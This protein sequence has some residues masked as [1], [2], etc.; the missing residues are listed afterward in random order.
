MKK[1]PSGLTCD[2][3]KK[4]GLIDEFNYRIHLTTIS[5]FQSNE[6]KLCK[7]CY[8]RNIGF[9]EDCSH[10]PNKCAACA[11]QPTITDSFTYVKNGFELYDTF[12]Y[13][14]DCNETLKDIVYKIIR[15]T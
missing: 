11:S 13:C 14:E 4:E 3:C 5:I 2:A 15:A 12:Y 9:D 7:D 10:F 8:Y 1:K 6:Y